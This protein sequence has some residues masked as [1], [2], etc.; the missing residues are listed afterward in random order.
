MSVIA[1]EQMGLRD[2]VR[3]PDFIDVSAPAAGAN[4]T[5][6]ISG[7]FAVRLLAATCRVNTDAN[8]ANRIL[9]VDYLKTGGATYV[10]N[11]PPVAITA[12]TVNQDVHFGPQYAQ[13]DVNANTPLVV[14]LLPLWLPPGCT[15]QV[16]L[17][18]IQVGDTLTNIRFVVE[19]ALAEA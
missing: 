18:N 7:V 15:I 19:R 13:F 2:V 1:D 16:T 12:S 8:A 4:A 10:R 3:V 11:L 14:P 6:A 5:F 9:S 17:D